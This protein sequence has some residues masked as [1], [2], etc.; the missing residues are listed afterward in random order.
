MNLQLVTM[1]H[2]WYLMTKHRSFSQHKRLYPPWFSTAVA[3]PKPL[4]VDPNFL[5]E[6]PK[7]MVVI[8]IALWRTKLIFAWKM[9]SAPFHSPRFT[10][11][12][13]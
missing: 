11:R 6:L 1:I 10:D 13:W 5:V 4:G 3:P 9:K 2:L 8:L 7:D 12:K